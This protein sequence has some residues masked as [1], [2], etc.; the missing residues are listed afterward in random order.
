MYFMVMLTR[1][2]NPGEP[3]AEFV[4]SFI[5]GVII[6]FGGIFTSH[7]LLTLEINRTNMVIGYKHE[8]AKK[9][10]DR[11]TTSTFAGY[12]GIKI[13]VSRHLSYISIYYDWERINNRMTY[14][15]NRAQAMQ[16]IVPTIDSSYQQPKTLSKK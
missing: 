7:V 6:G 15:Q 11:H 4:D 13:S 1:K 2:K 3:A 14:G 5:G 16:N 12:E 9:I 10:F 8:V